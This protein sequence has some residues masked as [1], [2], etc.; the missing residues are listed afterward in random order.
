MISSWNKLDGG[1]CRLTSILIDRKGWERGLDLRIVVQDDGASH[2]PDALGLG[3]QAAEVLRPFD[4]ELKRGLKHALPDLCRR[5]RVNI[6]HGRGLKV[7]IV[8]G[9]ST[10]PLE[11]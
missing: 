9:D 3:F 6:S 8:G 11:N 1:L 7:G 5:D 10:M 4:C 2:A